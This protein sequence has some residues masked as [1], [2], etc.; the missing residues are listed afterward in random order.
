MPEN[1]RFITLGVVNDAGSICEKE[2]LP[3]A[4][5]AEWLKGRLTDPASEGSICLDIQL[6]DEAGD[7]VQ[8]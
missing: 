4:E 8:G 2:T 3:L 1:R 6:T 7:P 5:L